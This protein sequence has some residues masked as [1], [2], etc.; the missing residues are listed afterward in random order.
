[1]KNYR[2]TAFS[3]SVSTMP[4]KRHFLLRTTPQP[5]TL[6]PEPQQNGHSKEKIFGSPVVAPAPQK[7]G[8]NLFIYFHVFN[9]KASQ[10]PEAVILSRQRRAAI[11][12]APDVLIMHL[13][14]RRPFLF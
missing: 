12:H 9:L 3:Q 11:L 4:W 5:H 6:W 13:A 14:T 8:N 10:I 7:F 1:M 2:I